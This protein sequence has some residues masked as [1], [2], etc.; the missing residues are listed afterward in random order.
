MTAIPDPL[1]ALTLPL[2]GSRLI[3]ASAGTGK[4]WT[5][6]ALYLRLVLGHGT[7]ATAFARPLSP[8]QILVM[9]FTRAATRELAERIRARLVEAAQCFQGALAPKVDDEFLLRLLDSYPPGSARQT[10]AWR[11]A[12][13]AQEMDDAAVFT[14]DAWCQRM[15]R[16]HA[17]D[18]G[19]SFDEDL[20]ADEGELTTQAVHDFWRQQ[21][22]PLS[23]AAL[24]GV[25]QVWPDVGALESEVK[26]RLRAAQAGAPPVADKDDS[27][28]DLWQRLGEPQQAQ[29]RTL[30]AQWAERIASMRQWL[31]ALVQSETNPLSKNKYGLKS[32]C[33]WFDALQAWLDDPAQQQPDLDDK[34]WAKLTPDGLRA[35]CNQGKQVEPPA[36]FNQ[37]ETLRAAL[38]D[39]ADLVPELQTYAAAQVDARL[40]ALKA[41]SGQFSFHDQ[42]ERLDA[43]LAGPQGE[44]L[45]S[46]ILEQYPVALIDEFQDTSALQFS[47]F[48]RLYGIT[49]AQTTHSAVLLI[50]DPKQSI[51]AFRGA[52]IASYLRAR[53]A[54]Q[55]RHSALQTNYRSTAEVVH[56]VNQLFERREQSAG[57]GAFLY[58]DDEAPDADNPVPFIAVGARGR[59]EQLVC[60]EGPV[61]ALTCSVH[62]ELE[63]KRDAR[64]RFAAHAAARIVSLL[65][66]TQAGFRQADGGFARL[67][68]SDIAVLV[69]DGDEARAVRRALQRRGVASVYLS[70]RDSVFASPEAADLLRWLRAVAEPRDGRLARAAFAAPTLGATIDE[71]AAL[72]TDDDVFENRLALLAELQ[73]IWLRQGV[74]PMLRQTLHRLD[75]PARW[76]SEEDGERRLTNVLHLAELLQTASGT[77]DGEQA[78]IRWLQEQMAGQST[79]EQ[80]VRLESEADLVRVVTIHKSKGLE[81]PLVFLPFATAFKEAKDG[82]DDRERLREDLRLLYVALTRAR[83]ALW[84]GI[85][86]L[87]VGKGSV[88]MLHRSAIGYLL[89]GDTPCEGAAIPGLLRE[90]FGDSPAVQIVDAAQEAELQRL[91][92]AHPAPALIEPPNYHAQ[93]ERNWSIGSFSA[94]VRDLTPRSTQQPAL[95]AALQDELWATE[96]SME[97]PS[98]ATLQ[99]SAARHRFPRGA[100]VGKFVHEQLA[101]LGENGFALSAQQTQDSLLQRCAR[102]GWDAPRSA[103]LLEWLSEVLVTPLPPLGVALPEIDTLLAEM[104]FW[105]PVERACAAEIDALCQRHIL[106]GRARPELT[107]RTLHGMVM[108][109][110]DL[111]FHHAGR[112]WVL[113]YKSNVLGTDDADYTQQALEAAVLEHRYDVQCALYM[114][115]LHRLLQARLR[116][117]YDPQTQLGGAIDLFLRGVRGPQ[118]G[119]VHIPPDGVL[120]DALDALFAQREEAA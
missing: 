92:A 38:A 19:H 91:Q 5:I 71:L 96:P 12:M 75:L 15:L 26:S 21:V 47:V 62:Q 18:S 44:R 65:N 32:V 108:G 64:E 93:F 72:A 107:E 42:L 22:Y 118:S 39:L 103:D 49:T 94:L 95:Q 6:A 34:T 58:R 104:E 30:K 17:F 115:A 23:G 20:L 53:Q 55:G 120:L 90:T 40:R 24:D 7:E 29:V 46:R 36:V 56:S 43:A 37:V 87:K 54:T 13:A 68:Q 31:C 41:A 66:D 86:A 105:L 106:P 77:L 109:F 45:R 52:D 63:S 35:G 67:R 89:G 101:W 80:V 1:D 102:Q 27:L 33:G 50:G 116:T 114:L 113:D 79:E 88:C 51:Y 28:L 84:V 48:N 10:A 78:L 110:A 59:A 11:L 25:L 112:Y 111:V 60:S 85:A 57:A 3:E 4:T 83:H 119:C 9:T 98:P 97:Q 74:L 82:A 69:R 16:E 2:Q 99:P 14:I 117:A 8:E 73:T 61:P 100:L 70:D 76:L 81:Y